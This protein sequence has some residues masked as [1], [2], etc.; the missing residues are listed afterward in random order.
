MKLKLLDYIIILLSVCGVVLY[1]ITVYRSSG[2][3]NEVHIRTFEKEYIYDLESEE[4]VDIDGLLGTTSVQIKNHAVRVLS[5]PCPLKI[6]MK[7]G[8]ISRADEWIACLPNGVFI[9][10]T[11]ASH[12]NPDIDSVT[13]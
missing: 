11:G 7:K 12:E 9:R 8:E 1:A 6:C 13:Y 4:V 3:K 5:S 10:I 2:G